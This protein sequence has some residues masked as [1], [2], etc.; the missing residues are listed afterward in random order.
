M[1]GTGEHTLMAAAAGLDA[2]GIDL[3]VGALQIAEKKARE[4]A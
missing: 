2:T 3:A 1:A 4:R